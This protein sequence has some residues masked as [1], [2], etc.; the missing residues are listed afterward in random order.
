[1]ATRLPDRIRGD[2][3]PRLFNE[4]II[5]GHRVVAHGPPGPQGEPGPEGP[6]GPPGPAGATGPQGQPGPPGTGTGGIDE[7][8]ADGGLY[9]RQDGD[10]AEIEELDGG[11]W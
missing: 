11:D 5:A 1:M 8:P 7:A 4:I 10:W 3:E 2:R 6:E 9:A